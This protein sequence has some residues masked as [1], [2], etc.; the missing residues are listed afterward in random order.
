MNKEKELNSINSLTKLWAIH[1][2]RLH[3]DSGYPYS[4]IVTVNWSIPM[5]PATVLTGH[6]A[7]MSWRVVKYLN[8]ASYYS[9][10]SHFVHLTAG[11]NWKRFTG[12]VQP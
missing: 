1:D 11:I 10:P 5:A 7:V 2:S 3:C 9:T 8:A 6:A 12:Q 4:E